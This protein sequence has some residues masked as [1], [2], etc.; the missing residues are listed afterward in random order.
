MD[1]SAKKRALALL[2]KRVRELEA[3]K[4]TAEKQTAPEGKQGGAA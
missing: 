1:E 3:E 2:E 4:K